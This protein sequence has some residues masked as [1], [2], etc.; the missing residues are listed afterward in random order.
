ML[1]NIARVATMAATVAL[2]GCVLPQMHRMAKDEAPIVTGSRVRSNFTPM[3][4]AFTCLARKIDMRHAAPLSIA[5]GDVKDYTGKYSQEEGSTITQGGALMVYSA[6]GKLGDSVR[7]AERFDTRIAELELAYTDRRQLGDGQP[8]KLEGNNGT[9]V[10][11]W[12]PYFGGS[13]QRSDYYIIGGIT[14]LNYNIQSGGVQFAINNSGIDARTFTMNIGADLRI[15]DTRTLRVV[16]TVSL[17]KQITGYEVGA[18]TFRF[19]GNRLFDVNIGAK[20]QEPLQLGVRT[21]L[22]QGALELVGAVTGTDAAGCI[23]QAE[24]GIATPGD[25]AM[26]APASRPAVPARP[27]VVVP[28]ANG[29]S[30]SGVP[31]VSAEPLQIQNAT[32]AGV[33]G[34]YQVE[35]EFGS[36]TLGA[37][38]L[39]GIDKIVVEA[40]RGHAVAVQI[41]ASDT[42]SWSPQRRQDI[43]NARI[44]AVTDALVDRGIQRS[45]IGITWTPSLSDTGMLRDGP[46][47]QIFA[48]LSISKP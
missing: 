35:F 10:V 33:G 20:N 26:T 31:M 23:A 21:T 27:P 17:E 37:V 22:E 19:F 9:S 13:I 25:P 41:I 48:K 14:E 18:S 8:H 11:P 40:S 28:A 42:E 36:E 34:L 30:T 43:T 1:K 45:R 38:A 3:E 5:V 44:R 4:G 24:A 2:T 47:H 7:I 39:S 46:G 29:S 16:K 15:V 12:L 32:D 6:L